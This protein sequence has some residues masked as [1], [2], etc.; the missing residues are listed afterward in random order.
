MVQVV[1]VVGSGSLGVELDLD[2]IAHE[3]DAVVDYDPAKYPGAYFRIEESKPLVTLYRTGK[4][5]VT[6]GGSEEEV[7]ETRTGFLQLL[8]EHGILANARDEWFKI[9]NYVCIADAG[10]QI[11]LPYWPL[12]SV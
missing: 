1:N 8:R 2:A 10:Q 5:I 12:F 4:F 6:G 7:S 3:L 9:Q 11:N